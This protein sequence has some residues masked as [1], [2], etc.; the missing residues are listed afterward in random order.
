MAHCNNIAATSVIL[1][2]NSNEFADVLTRHRQLC[3]NVPCTG[4][5]LDEGPRVLMIAHKDFHC[6]GAN[7]PRPDQDLCYVAEQR[8]TEVQV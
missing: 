2:Q 8:I 4:V 7:I 1:A 5:L 6:E 3:L